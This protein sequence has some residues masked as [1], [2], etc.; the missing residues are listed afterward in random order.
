MTN[1]IQDS[2]GKQT[3]VIYDCLEEIIDVLCYQPDIP[4]QHK[5]DMQNKLGKVAEAYY[6][7]IN[8]CYK[9]EYRKPDE[10]EGIKWCNRTDE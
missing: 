7:D 5:V 3:K 10:S 9:C 6:T 2:M 4:L 1:P 8:P